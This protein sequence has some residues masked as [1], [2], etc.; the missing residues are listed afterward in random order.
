MS[1][2]AANRKTNI[3]LLRLSFFYSG[4]YLAINDSYYVFSTITT[5]SKYEAEEK[6]KEINGDLATILDSYT[7]EILSVA[8]NGQ[9][10]N[11]V[12]KSVG[13]NL[14]LLLLKRLN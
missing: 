14:I 8:V 13:N 1:L 12:W 4:N 7:Q 5:F 2:H 6:C 9:I 3:A 11:G 10:A